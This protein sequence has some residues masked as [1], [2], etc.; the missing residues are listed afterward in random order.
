M[1]VGFV[2]HTAVVFVI[3]FVI[4]IVVLVIDRGHPHRLSIKLHSYVDRIIHRGLDSVKRPCLDAHF[5]DLLDL[6]LFLPLRYQ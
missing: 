3:V 1:L 2:N 4:I 5:C 6:P